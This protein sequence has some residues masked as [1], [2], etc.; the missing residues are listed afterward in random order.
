MFF[1]WMLNLKPKGECSSQ[2]DTN[3]RERMLRMLLRSKA[4]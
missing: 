2:E 4:T 1:F 3:Y